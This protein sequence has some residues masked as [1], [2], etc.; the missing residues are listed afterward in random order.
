M[1]FAPY[2]TLAPS[3]IIS[4]KFK[5]EQM[6]KLGYTHRIQRPDYGDM[7]PFVNATDPKNISTGNPNLL[8]EIGDK[9]ELSY[10]QPVAKKG[11]FSATL[12]MRNNTNDI[13]WYTYFYPVYKVGD[14]TYSNVAVRVR[15]NIGHEDNYGL[16]LFASIPFGEKLNIR[17]NLSG[18][19]RYIY[20]GISSTGDV[21]G[22]NY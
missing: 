16:N 17:T 15:E 12:F 8:P 13:Q 2:N 1:T 21:H 22:F 9:V 5:K 11:N 3:A 19:E 20:T 10:S 6:L 14:S 7:N 18:F 4:H